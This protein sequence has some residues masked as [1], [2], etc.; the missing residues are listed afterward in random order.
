MRILS[1]AIALSFGLAAATAAAPAWAQPGKGVEACSAPPAIGETIAC[2]CEVSGPGSSVWGAGPYT[3]DSDICIAAAHAGLLTVIET[4]DGPA[5]FGAVD[6]T[7]SEGCDS[8]ESSTANGVTTQSYGAWRQSFFFPAVQTGL[9]PTA[10]ADDGPGVDFGDAPL[11]PNSMPDGVKS[12]TCGCTAAAAET[13]F[14]WGTDRYSDDSSICRAALHAGAISTD[15]GLVT[16]ARY[17]AVDG[18]TGSTRNG[19]TTNDWGAY[20]ETIGFR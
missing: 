17:G 6:V 12:L 5:L 2:G 20:P 3:H 11:C 1:A 19:V 8:Y 15:G 9:C 18:L 10:A 16:V 14:V 13:G 4:P 7:G